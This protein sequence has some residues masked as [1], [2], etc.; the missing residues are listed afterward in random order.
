MRYP[1]STLWLTAPAIVLIG[2]FLFGLGRLLLNSVWHDGAF[3]VE[4]Y[5]AY[6]QRPDQLHS[7]WRTVLVALATTGLSLLLAFPTAY[8]IA[9]YRGNRNRL[10]VL[11]IL[12]WLVSVVVRTYGWVVILGPRGLINGSLQWLGLMDSP[13]P[14]MFNA[15]G[16][17]LGLVH[18]LCPFMIVAI[19][20][21]LLRIDPAVEEASMS[22]GAR[23]WATFWRVLLPLSLPGILTGTILVWLMSIGAIVTPLMLGGM[24]DALIGTEIFEQVMHFFDYRRAAALSVVLLLVGLAGVL[25]LQWLE[26][27]VT[28][29][30]QEGGAP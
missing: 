17:V 20:A 10:L 2:L 14:L 11:I 6:L 12:P 25:P 28:R 26:R 24:R 18:V 7:L 3:N 21:S 30:A 1:R 5:Q 23:P 16:V 8:F 29:T 4:V 22:L 19:L 13:L 15:F 9:R 27:R